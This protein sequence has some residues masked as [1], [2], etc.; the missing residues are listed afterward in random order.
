MHL[1][2]FGTVLSTVTTPVA[3]MDGGESSELFAARGGGKI[4]VSDAA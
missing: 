2:F 3:F 1:V 4:L